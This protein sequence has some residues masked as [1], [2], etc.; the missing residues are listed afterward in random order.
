MA[1][2]T[3]FVPLNQVTAEAASIIKGST[4]KDRLLFK[5]WVYRGLREIGPGKQNIDV[6][7]LYPVDLSFKKPEDCASIID[8]ALFS[9]T[10]EE[11]KYTYRFGKSRIHRSRNSYINDGVYSL[12][13][14]A[15][16]DVSEDDFYIH[17]GSNGN[18][19]DKAVVR[20]FK[21]PID[22][23]GMPKIPEDQVFALMLFI[24]YMWAMRDNDNRSE[25]EQ[26]YNMWLRER[27]RAK[28]R[29]KMPSMLEGKQ[30]AKNWMSLI[31]KPFFD[32]F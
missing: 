24:R 3:K 19:V 1:K 29:N 7:T 23:E 26:N 10:G 25:I 9:S 4:E 5:Q 2:I 27:D 14:D 15:L 22:E 18:T 30:I 12:S 20:Y 31:D 13:V 21:F 11:L 32:N 16:V 6:C 8:V 28:S 17:M